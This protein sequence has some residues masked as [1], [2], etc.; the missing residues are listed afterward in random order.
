[1]TMAALRSPECVNR[2]LTLAGPKAYTTAEVIEM[3][4][5]M[6]DSKVGAA[7]VAGFFAVVNAGLVARGGAAGIWGA[8]SHAAGAATRERAVAWRRRRTR[9]PHSGTAPARGG[10]AALWPGRGLLPTAL[11]FTLL[12]RPP[13][14]PSHPRAGPDQHCADLAAAGDAQRAA[15]QRL[16][17]R[18]VGPPGARA[19]RSLG[20]G[21]WGFGGGGGNA[22][23]RR[24]ARPRA[25]L[26]TAAPRPVFASP[27]FAI[28]PS[29]HPALPAPR[30]PALPAQAFA[31]VLANN[32]TWAAP[33]DQTYELLGIEPGSV[34]TLEAYLKVGVCL[35]VCVLACALVCVCVCVCVCVRVCPCR[36]CMHVWG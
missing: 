8:V 26:S 12:P 20:L 22:P 32:E 10:A 19:R 35:C 21:R 4:E 11:W 1:M 15:R 25:P 33:M 28:A 23:A 6:S 30:P 36:A 9:S 2:T 18:R 31:E 7:V 34:N 3:C 29:A 17:A 24:P 16:G 13:R 5:D 27:L 14:A